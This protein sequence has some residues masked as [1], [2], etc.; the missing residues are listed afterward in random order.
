MLL[1][2]ASFTANVL[3][4]RALGEFGEVNVWLIACSRGLVGLAMI[5][6]VYWRD[7]QPTHL[8]QRWKVAERGIVGNQFRVWR[9][10]EPTRNF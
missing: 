6:A 2:A 3:L 5:C 4:V 1:S 8:W 9:E 10:P 7:F